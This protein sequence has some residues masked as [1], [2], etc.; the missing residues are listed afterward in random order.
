MAQLTKAGRY[1]IV[2]EIGRGSMG[3]VYQGFDPVIGRGVA[4]KTIKTEGLSPAEYREYKARFHR[5]A[6]AAGVLVHPNI[7]TIYDFGEDEGTLYLAMELLS[8]KTLQQLLEERGMLPVDAIVPIFEQVGSALDRAHQ[9]QVIH[10]DIKPGNIMVLDDGLVKVTDFGIAKLMSA[11][12]TRAG[13]VLGSPSYMSPEQ[14]KGL[15]IDGRADIFSLG[16][17]LYECLTGTKPFPGQNISTIIYKIIHEEPAYPPELDREFHPGI[18]HVI[19]KSLAKLPEDRYQTCREMT[20]D[21]RN[22]RSIGTAAEPTGIFVAGTA[23]IAPPSVSEVEPPAISQPEAPP[24]EETMIADSRAPQIAGGIPVPRSFSPPAAPERKSTFS[25]S[26]TGG[27]TPPAPQAQVEPPISVLEQAPPGPPAPEAAALPGRPVNVSPVIPVSA[28]PAPAVA[29]RQLK[30]IVALA[31]VAIVGLGALVWV[32]RHRH[33]GR[34][35]GI[36]AGRIS[37]VSGDPLS[38]VRIVLRDQSSGQVT[39]VATDST[40]AYKATGLAP[41]TYRLTVEAPESFIS[42]EISDLSLSGSQT[43]TEDVA[44]A[45]APVEPGE[46]AGKVLDSRGRP[47]ARR[48]VKVVSQ[49]TQSVLTV[50]TDARGNYRIP[51]LPP[52]TYDVS[53]EPGADQL[54]AGKSDVHLGPG[55]S[56]RLD[57]TAAKAAATAPPPSQPS[58]GSTPPRLTAVTATVHGRVFDENGAGLTGASVKIIDAQRKVAKAVISDSAGNFRITDLAPGNYHLEVQPQGF[59][60]TEATQFPLIKGQDYEVNI[61]V[62]ELAAAKAPA[63][64]PPPSTGTLSGKVV[65]EHGAAIQGLKVRLV[66]EGNGQS[67]QQLTTDDKGAFAA[68][69]L[70]AGTYDIQVQ[71]SALYPAKQIQGLVIK[72]GEAVTQAIS[73]AGPMV[74]FPVAHWH[75]TTGCY[76]YL[77]IT[78]STIRYEEKMPPNNR[79]HSFELPSASLVSTKQWSFLFKP[80]P[81]VEL[82]FKNGKSYPFFYIRES[83]LNQPNPTLRY[84]DALPWQD[85]E[86]AVKDYDA[87]L[88]LAKKQAAANS[89]TPSAAHN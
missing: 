25:P 56:A 16:V 64:P 4:I 29:G 81:A 46:L 33:A 5:E 61:R 85:L 74:R 3:V 13:L 22:Y 27:E 41:G 58:G 60:P 89:A 51:D 69:D 70:I 68:S 37:S 24:I 10:R 73:L 55:E 15:P 77:Y 84:S 62:K 31:L 87:A 78:R 8:G 65:D 2:K 52:G 6:Q 66:R 49:A 39:Q 9:H 32:L 67:V 30:W 79:D 28:A 19:N 38:G 57:L 12:M 54:A 44:L 21:L 11:S 63:T 76:G 17:V 53:L 48:Q 80:F 86:R 88:A 18:R 72:P 36:I 26:L 40:G 47:L 1:Q 43:L 7:L 75:R 34:P 59:S 23:G 82:K 50:E 71:P 14:I 42:K 45:P 83:L 35:N 20:S